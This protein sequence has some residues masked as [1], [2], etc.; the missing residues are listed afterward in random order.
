MRFFLLAT[1]LLLLAACA[2]QAPVTTSQAPES[3]A[4]SLSLRL[5]DHP[6]AAEGI[7]APPRSAEEDFIAAVD[8]ASNV[9]FRFGDCEIDRAGSELLRSHAERLKADEKLQVTLVGHTDDLGS[10]AYNIA[11]A[12]R[13]LKAVYRLLRKHGVAQSQIRLYSAGVEKDTLSCHSEACHR[14]MRRVELIYAG[15]S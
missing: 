10:R 9:F 13:R 4:Q 5:A 14:L 6:G 1:P 15:N 12:D 8:P 11:I 7:V 3:V 2:V